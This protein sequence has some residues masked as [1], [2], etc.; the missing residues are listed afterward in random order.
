MKNNTSFDENVINQII[1]ELESENEFTLTKRQVINVA[2]KIDDYS[3]EDEEDKLLAFEYSCK[4]RNAIINYINFCVQ[5]NALKKYYY[6]NTIDYAINRVISIIS[7]S[8]VQV[9]YNNAGLERDLLFIEY[10]LRQ[11]VYN[12]RNKTLSLKA[13]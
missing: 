11:K 13:N 8:D 7:G 12:K 10:N 6:C 4:I 1:N 3:F 2:K 5:S 9:I